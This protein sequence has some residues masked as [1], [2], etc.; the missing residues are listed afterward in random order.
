M[1]A[2]YNNFQIDAPIITQP[3]GQDTTNF[4]LY[5]THLKTDGDDHC[6]VKFSMDTSGR[7][8]GD[9][10]SVVYD[11]SEV[12]QIP[13]WVIKL[14]DVTIDGAEAAL[15]LA[16]DCSEEVLTEGLGT[17]AVPITNKVIGYAADALTFAVD[18]ANLVLKFIFKLEE[19]G[20]TL[21][22]TSIV[23]QSIHRLMTAYVK[24]CVER[25][26]ITID[27][28]SDTTSE[29]QLDYTAV[30][31]N[32]FGQ[33]GHSWSSTSNNY[34]KEFVVGNNNY[35]FWMPDYAPG[36]MKTGLLVSFKIDSK[37]TSAN[38]YAVVNILFS[39]TGNIMALQGSVLYHKSEDSGWSPPG[40]GMIT[41]NTNSNGN[42]KLV[43][44][45]QGDDKHTQS[46]DL[47][48]TNIEAAYK[49]CFDAA[50]ALTEDDVHYDDGT[51]AFPQVTLDV[52]E[53]IRKSII[54]GQSGDALNFDI[55]AYTGQMLFGQVLLPNSS[56][57][58]NSGQYKLYYQMDGNLAVY[59]DDV[60]TWAA[61]TSGQPG[62]V[63]I[64]GGR[65]HI[66]NAA[67]TSIWDSGNAS[68]GDHLK[69]QDDGNVVLFSSNNAAQWETL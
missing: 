6:T 24:T 17:A 44:L 23:A 26:G 35:D 3:S 7:L 32:L 46:T 42:R 56:L 50:F 63:S 1:I 61:M 9:S 39:P 40:T 34:Y 14:A 22:F 13:D 36:F 15:K 19:N 20:G 58:S 52:I 67:G 2:F 37:V 5:I 18:H 38:D 12:E 25:G 60:C 11:M 64:V 21:Y 43:Q 10:F 28:T 30:L 69:M 65:L 55:V 33:S 53:A 68:A 31:T 49:A 62:H 47:A 27:P 16:V 51:R 57:V 4:Q 45:T 8:V 29:L 54:V 48:G 59:N 41:W 66:Y